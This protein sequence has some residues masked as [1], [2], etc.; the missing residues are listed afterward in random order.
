MQLEV[1]R[2]QMGPNGEMPLARMVGPDGRV[3][4]NYDVA[5][6]LHGLLNKLGLRE[7]VISN[8]HR[9]FA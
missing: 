5:A 8:E 7:E 6:R 4:S 1:L 9:T 3:T 2:A